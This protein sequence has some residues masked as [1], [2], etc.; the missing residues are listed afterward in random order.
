MRE[1]TERSK[2]RRRSSGACPW[3][4][5]RAVG[6]VVRVG[7]LGREQGEWGEERLQRRED[8]GEVEGVEG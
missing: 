2:E 6:M 3:G 8:E 5:G 4:R 1:L 7:A